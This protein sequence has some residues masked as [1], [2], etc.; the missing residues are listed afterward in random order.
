MLK[1]YAD[2]WLA[3]LI[4]FPGYNTIM[5]YGFVLS[6][7]KDYEI[8]NSLRRH[9]ITHALQF[10]ETAIV[11][12]LLAVVISILLRLNW[13]QWVISLF[14]GVSF[15]YV[16]YVISCLIQSIKCLFDS[17]IP[18]NDKFHRGYRNSCYEEEARMSGR[19]VLYYQSR[20]FFFFK[21]VRFIF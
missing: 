5:L 13:C 16:M 8:T 21:W 2:N 14:I 12:V 19:D 9:E 6:K 3:K 4:L 17:S 20:K 15:Y 11:A 18:W 10:W 7:R 1:V